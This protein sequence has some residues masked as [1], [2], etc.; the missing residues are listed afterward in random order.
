MDN[1]N[2]WTSTPQGLSRIHPGLLAGITFAGA[3]RQPS[4][5]RDDG[6]LTAVEAQQ[7][8]LAG[9]DLIVLSACETAL[10]TSTHGEGLMGL[11]RAFQV[12]GAAQPRLH[13]LAS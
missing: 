8:D 2:Y 6:I 3:N 10:G 11:Q 12:A 13:P 4:P 1:Q 9:T 7:L 5:D